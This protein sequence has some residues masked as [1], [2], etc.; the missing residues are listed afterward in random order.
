MEGG[1]AVVGP[2]VVVV[3][4]GVH[5]VAA[6]R[7]KGGKEGGKAERVNEEVGVEEFRCFLMD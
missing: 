2:A 3:G 4:V 5:H 6:G 1:Q 7:G